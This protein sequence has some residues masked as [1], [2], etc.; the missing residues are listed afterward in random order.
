MSLDTRGGKQVGDSTESALGDAFYPLFEWL[1]D[2]EGD[3]VDGVE[4]KLAEARMADNVEMFL[5]RAL[6][7]GTIAGLALWFLLIFI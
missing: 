6:A 2:P 3:F 4:T 7:V 1:F 5:S